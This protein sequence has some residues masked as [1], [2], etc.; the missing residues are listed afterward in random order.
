MRRRLIVLLATAITAAGFGFVGTSPAEA[1]IACKSTT[2]ALICQDGLKLI[3]CEVSGC[4]GDVID[5]SPQ[6]LPL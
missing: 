6:G 1:R 4:A 2:S 3:I 5:T